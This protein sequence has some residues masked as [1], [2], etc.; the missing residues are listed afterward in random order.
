M[1]RI[2]QAGPGVKLTLG[3]IRGGKH[4]EIGATTGRRP[5]GR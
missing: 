2:A 5:E 3:I 1:G 4:L